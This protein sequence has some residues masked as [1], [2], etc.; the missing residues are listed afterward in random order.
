MKLENNTEQEKYFL[1]PGYILVSK[2]PYLIST[3]LGSCIAVCLWDSVQ[4]FGG[5]NHYLYARTFNNIRNSQSGNVSI[6]YMI[7]LLIDLGAQKHNLKAHII[8]G[9]QNREMQSST[10]GRDNIKIAEKILGDNY[11]DIVTVDVGGDM[12]R[13]VTFDNYSGEVVV[14]K[15]NSLR[16]CDWYA[17]QSINS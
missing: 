8:G 12:G 1:Q 2:D 6:P 3:V 10:I 9:A 4:K 13:K 17:D 7:K 16:R 14:Y 5:M 11:I 15:V